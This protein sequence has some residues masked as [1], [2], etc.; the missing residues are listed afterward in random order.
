MMRL[1]AWNDKAFW[2]L[3]YLSK[4]FSN[5]EYLVFQCNRY[6]VGTYRNGSVNRRI[7]HR[8]ESGDIDSGLGRVGSGGATCGVFET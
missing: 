1:D 5:F 7:F 2:V 4:R 3:S 6:G 8:D